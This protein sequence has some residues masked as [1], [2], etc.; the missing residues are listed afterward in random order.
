MKTKTNKLVVAAAAGLL[1]LAGCV[2]DVVSIQIQNVVA[3]GV[4]AD[5][6]VSG[7]ELQQ[8]GGSIDVAYMS[9]TYPAYYLALNVVSHLDTAEVQS[10]GSTVSPS[11]RNDFYINKVIVGY[12]GSGISLEDEMDVS[13]R[14]SAGGGLVMGMNVLSL[15]AFQRMQQF[16]TEEAKSVLLTIKLSGEFAHGA[17]LTTGEFT[18]PITFY[19]SPN[20][21]PVCTATQTVEPA[22]D[23]A[24]PP[25]G[26]WGQ[27]GYRFVCVDAEAASP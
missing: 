2:D 3:N 4:G 20:P 25:C 22:V 14:V 13:G 1:G 9:E 19:Q 11:A 12:E 18:F 27:D 10:G 26:N 21:A 6:T 16:S 24:I 23:G 17:S 8:S 7:S 15:R 5:C